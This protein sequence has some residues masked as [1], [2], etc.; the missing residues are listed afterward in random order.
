MTSNPVWPV[1]EQGD[2]D[3]D[4]IDRID[5][6]APRL[7]TA[8]RCGGSADVEALM[9]GMSWVHLAALAISVA[10]LVD[11]DENDP[12][13]KVRNI[14]DSLEGWTVPQ[15]RAAHAAYQRGERDTRTKD[16]ERIYCREHRRKQST[17][18]RMERPA[19]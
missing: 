19:S 7:A 15:L 1:T 10:T 3:A 12:Q 6:L 8:V 11:P 14:R 18:Q 2:L 9:R 17:P 4:T 13:F 5:R 16:G